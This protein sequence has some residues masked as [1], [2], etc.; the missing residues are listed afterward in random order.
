VSVQDP[1]DL[2]TIEITGVSQDEP[3]N[4]IATALRGT[5]P[6]TVRLR[7]QRS[8][9]GDGRVYRISFIATGGNN[10]CWGTVKVGVPR[11]GS[12]VE[13]NAYYNALNPPGG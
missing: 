9:T 6:D 4:N 7:A 13:S 11:N 3:T 1:Q 12:A 10:N 5:T 2:E 8:A